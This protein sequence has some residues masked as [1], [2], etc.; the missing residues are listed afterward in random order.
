MALQGLVTTP[1]PL[2]QSSPLSGTSP[3]PGLVGLK[4]DE[5]GG[6]IVAV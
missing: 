5:Q 6:L 2:F 4:Q 3:R 1:D